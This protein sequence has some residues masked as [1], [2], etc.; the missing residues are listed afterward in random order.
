MYGIGREFGD[1]ARHVRCNA[2][3]DAKHGSEL[4]FGWSIGEA[5][6]TH[7]AARAERHSRVVVQY[8]S[9]TAVG[10]GFQTVALVDGVTDADRNIASTADDERGAGSHLDAPRGW[11]LSERGRRREQQNGSGKPGQSSA[12]AVAVNTARALELVHVLP[13]IDPDPHIYR[14]LLHVP[15][16]RHREAGASQLEAVTRRRPEVTEVRAQRDLR[17][18]RP[19]ELRPAEH[20]R[21][22]A[23]VNDVRETERASE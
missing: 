22:D 1:S 19:R 11:L 23:A 12:Q 5:I 6:E 15:M 10:A 4:S 9:D 14:P 2:S 8:D 13:F 18:V 20:L 17:K 7:L 16:A 3:N 21:A